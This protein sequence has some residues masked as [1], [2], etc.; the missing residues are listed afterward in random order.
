M[1][2]VRPDAALT[3]TKQIQGAAEGA[4]AG[5]AFEEALAR[6]DGSKIQIHPPEGPKLE[7]GAQTVENEARVKQLVAEK[8]EQAQR[9]GGIEKLGADIEMGNKRMSELIDQ[10]KGGETFTPQELL[11]MQAEMHEITLQ[12]EVTTKVVAEAVSGV[13]NLVQQQA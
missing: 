13:K 3:A 11:G 9:P 12:I 10:L 6:I 4:Q 1:E 2:V 7:A 5:K 8:T